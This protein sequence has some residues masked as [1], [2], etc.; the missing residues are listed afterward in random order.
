MKKLF[1]LVVIAT[2]TIF[3]LA[4]CSTGTKTQNDE[5]NN[6]KQPNVIIILADDMGFS[7]LSCYG[8]EINTPN[9]DKLAESGVRFTQ[10][11]NAARCC[12]T[13]ASL[14]TGI[15]PH[16]AGLGGMVNKNANI[17]EGPY[18]GY[19]SK[20]SITIAEVLKEAG[21]YTASSGKWHVG[22]DRPN[23][24]IDRG[25]DNHYGLVSGAM[26]YFDVT[27]VKAKGNHRVFVED[28]TEFIPSNE[29]FYM[30]NAITENAI[31]Y[32][33]KAEGKDQPFFM[34]L[35]YTAPHWP[36]HAMQEDIDLFKG[37]YMEGW[38]KL[39]EDR[40]ERMREMGIIDSTWVLSE[41]TEDIQAWDELSQ[42]QKERMDQL[43]AIYAAMVHRLD[44]GIGDV[45]QQVEAMGELEN[46]IV[47]FL[48]DNGGSGEYDVFG[49]DFWGNFWD[50]EAE[51]G[52]ADSYHTLGAAWANLNN[53]PFRYYKKDVHEGGIATPMIV[54]WPGSIKNPGSLAHQSGH[55]NDVMTTICEITGAKY[56]ETYKGNAITQMQ[57]KS[58]API[59]KGESIE[60]NNPIF[61]EHNGNRAVREGEWKL[62]ARN[63]QPWELYNFTNDRTEENNLI[64]Q[65]KEIAEALIEKYE[66]WAKEIGV[67]KKVKV[68]KK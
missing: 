29:N 33:K 5:E 48:S 9:I 68:K 60:N 13:R 18:Q 25:F 35:A 7:D 55:I 52:S 22:E 38:D 50:G 44:I 53:A 16:Q 59:L 27:K 49:T 62:V 14:L 41:R 6:A 36:L 32:L 23:W 61:F 43:M 67:D 51:P 45:M 26:N 40:F 42:E 66:A 11:Y 12:P 19:L 28:S 17:P 37:K 56:P 2:L 30:T 65:H 46:T 24:P 54:S 31:K 15:Y 47:M 10:F 1:Q 64:A 58:F 8:S 57:G 63:G 4:S 3:T 34:Y 21:Y 39:R 20:H